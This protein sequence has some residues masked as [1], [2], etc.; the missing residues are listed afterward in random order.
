MSGAIATLEAPTARAGEY[1]AGTAIMPVDV[2]AVDTAVLID[3]GAVGAFE[4]VDAAEMVDVSAVHAAVLTAAG[5]FTS[6]FFNAV[7]NV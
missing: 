6:S 5:E 7:T 1:G 3:V 2:S 4:P